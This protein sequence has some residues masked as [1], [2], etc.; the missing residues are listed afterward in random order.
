MHHGAHLRGDRFRE[1]LGDVSHLVDAAALHLRLVTEEFLDRRA[2]RLRAVNDEQPY[3]IRTN[4]ALDEV[5]QE[6]LGHSRVLAP[7]LLEPQQMLASLGVHADRAQ[8]AVAVDDDPVDPDRQNVNLVGRAEVPL[9]LFLL[10]PRRKPGPK[11]PSA[12][13]IAA[14]IALKRRNPCFGCVRIAQQIARA[15]G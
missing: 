13:L 4:P 1:P 9:A 12:E 11:G 8:D 6:V 3:P 2:Q 5:A 14:I 15:F 7:A 10:S